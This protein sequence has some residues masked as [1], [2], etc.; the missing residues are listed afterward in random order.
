MEY[1]P[2]DNPTFVF[3]PNGISF[4]SK[5]KVKLLQQENYHQ[6]HIPFNLKGNGNIFVRVYTLLFYNFG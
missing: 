5:C 6:D 4:R 2:G 3:K 1:D